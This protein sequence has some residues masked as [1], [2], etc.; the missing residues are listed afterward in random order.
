[1]FDRD[2]HLAEASAANVFLIAG[3]LL[4]TPRLKPDVFPGITRQVFLELARSKGIEV[5]E[6]ELMRDEL[7]EIDGA[8]VCSTLMEIRGLTRLDE[9]ALPTLELGTYKALVGAFRML[10]HQ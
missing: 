5:R 1:M 2:G 7:A 10:T 9:R 4:L 3:S 6:V 8:F